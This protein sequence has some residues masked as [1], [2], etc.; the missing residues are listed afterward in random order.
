MASSRRAYA[1]VLASMAVGGLLSVLAYSMTWATMQVALLP[2]ED[3]LARTVEQTGRDLAPA[4]AVAAWVACAAVLGVVA[5]RSWGRVLV[6]I[7]AAAA[8]LVAAGAGT[9]FALTGEPGASAW[10]VLAVIGGLLATV[11]GFVTILNGR[12]WPSMGAR[13]ERGPARRPSDW[14]AQDEG[15]DP[16]DDLVE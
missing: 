16:T 9:G 2:G 8:G 7:A 13:Y 4:G 5:T 15:R 1:L 3:A 14:D 12:S 6:G 11:A 10:W